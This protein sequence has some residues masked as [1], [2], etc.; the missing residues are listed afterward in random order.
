MRALF[1]TTAGA[2]HFGLMV[3]FA[4]A[5]RDAGHEVKVA[6]PASFAEAVAATGLDHA[7][8]ADVPHEVL[9]PI[10]GRL[11]ELS[12]VEADRTVMAEVFGRL[13]ARA[14]LPGLTEIMANWRPDVVV[15]EFCEFG[16]LVAAQKAGVPQV[17]VA[18]GF[19]ATL[20]SAL[21]VVAS[22]LAE[23]DATAGCPRGRPI[24][25]WPPGRS[26]VASQPRSTA[27]TR[28]AH[29]VSGDSGA[30]PWP[31]CKGRHHRHGATRTI[32]S[33]TSPSGR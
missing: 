9:G 17:E 16:S 3:P 25:R 28:R 20:D 33:C 14:A 5:C 12:R 2:G 10:F 4:R 6:A 13:D 1:S 19:A 7:P 31:P 29:S 8:F 32:P 22:P 15:R 26:S 27:R 18:I 21:P 24:G 30:P 11:P 23:L